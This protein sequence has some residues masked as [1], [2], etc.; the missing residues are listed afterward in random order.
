MRI[1]YL[2]PSAQLGGAERSLVDLLAGVR[3]RKPDW[4]LRLILSEDGPLVSRIQDLGVTVDIVEMPPELAELGDSALNHAGK[5]RSKMDVA[6]S[7][8]H[9]A[10]AFQRY[11]RAL[12]IHLDRITPNLVHA[13]GFK[14]Q[15]LGAFTRRKRVPLIWHVHDY[16]STRALMSWG[17][18]M[19]SHRVTQVLANS[20][21][22]A[23]DVTKVCSGG[24]PVSTLYNAI[25]IERFCPAGPVADLDGD[26][27]AS[28]SGQ[29]VRIGMAGT[30]ARW[31]GHEVFLQAVSLLPG[32]LNISAYVVG[33][34]VYRTA[35][36]QYTLEEL[37]GLASRLGIADRVRFTGF[38]EDVPAAMR[39]LDIVV[40]AS[41]RAEP[42]GLVI[43]EGMACG[44]AVIASRAGGALEIFE[45]DVSAVSHA[46]GDA[47]ELARQ[48]ERLAR[49]PALRTG[50]GA[51]GRASIEA[52]FQRGRLG[53]ELVRV[54]ETL[55][56]AGSAAGA[57]S[58]LNRESA[59]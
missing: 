25:D 33:G 11:S 5:T 54:Y 16:V 41:T 17:W 40:H 35:G 20:K 30:F 27:K 47:R 8:V 26:A 48:M 59:A 34:P 49:D 29:T 31:K 42:F 46:P 45:E 43:A 12:S 53:D 44:R 56:P 23:Q 22:V 13:T 24:L 10:G 57:A 58:Q 37:R 6:R 38:L 15:M 32:D 21:S 39:A 28:G 19:L 9:A 14:M 3:S 50:L 1:A 2:N 55:I 4:E 52:N 51:K 7:L 36:S 18:R